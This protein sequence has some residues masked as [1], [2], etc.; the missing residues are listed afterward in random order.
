[1]A[2]YYVDNI[3][4]DDNCLGTTPASAVR[5]YKTLHL[6]AGDTV[7]FKR[8]TE[9]SEPLVI[10]G[11]DD[12]FPIAYGS[13]DEG[14]LPVFCGSV[15][16]SR[17]EDWVPTERENVWRLAKDIPT[18][19]GNFVFNTDEC[20]ATLRWE[21]DGLSGQGDFF[22]SRFAECNSNK[23][24]AVSPQE[25]LMYS[26]GNPACVY[27]H[28]EAVP[29]GTRSLGVLKSNVVISELCFMNSGVHGLAAVGDTKNVTVRGCLFKNIGGCGWSRSDRIRLG[30]GIEFWIGADNILIENNV[31]KNIYDSCATHQ[32]PDYETPPARNFH[33]RGNLF[34]T[35]SMAAFEYRAQMMVDSS[36]T[37]NV[38]RHAG[39]GFGMLGEELPR[40]SEIWPQPMGH[41]IFLWR[42]FDAVEGG[43]LLIADNIFEDSPVGAAIY[44]II[45]KEAEA[46]ITFK[47][48]IYSEDCLFAAHFGGQDHKTKDWS[49]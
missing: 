41:H 28:I 18:D 7:L 34:D 2:T 10:V 35:Y 46:Q 27:S 40:R 20:T 39:C 8:G 42:I 43:S 32:G 17:A 37:D 5:D 45:C 44:S 38:C 16:V 6:V 24:R 3:Y 48:N 9:Y 15:D 30:N 19:V 1:M 11:G 4:G 22:D 29:Y 14:T 25:I 49:E 36:F 33:C 31:F 13:Y 47:G 23:G 21:R 12:G 26:I